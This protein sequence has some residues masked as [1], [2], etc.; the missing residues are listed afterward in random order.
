MQGLNELGET[1]L[2]LKDY[3]RA[4]DCQTKA[5]DI[6]VFLQ[7]RSEQWRYEAAAGKAYEAKGDKTKAIELL[8]AAAGTLRGVRSRIASEG[9]VQRFSEQEEPSGVYKLLIDLLMKSGRAEEARAYVD[10]S[11]SKLVKDAFGGVKPTV[12]D[13]ALKETLAGVDTSE[14]KKEAIEQEIRAERQKPEE[15][16]D[17][18]KLE[19]LTK[20]LAATEGEFNQW[21]MKLKFQ[22]RRMYDALSIKPATLGDV[23]RQV[24]AGAVFLEYFISPE[25]LYVFCIGREYF[26]ARSTAIAE[27]ELNTLVSRFVRACQ[28][29]PSGGPD[30]RLLDQ[31][32]RLYEVLIAPVKDVVAKYE[33]VVIVPFGPLYYLPFHALVTDESGKPEYLIERKRISYTTSATFADILKDQVRGHKSFMGFGNPDGSLPAASAELQG[34]QDK[35]FKSGAKVFTS[36]KATK[37]A[38]F[39]QAKNADILHLA[40]HGVIETNPL[41]S[42][43]LFAGATKEAQELTLLEVAGYTALRER[44][45]LVFLSACQTAKEA[46]KS[47]SGSELITLAEAFAMAGAPTLIATLWEV[48]D[49]ATRLFSETFYDQLANKN[50]DKLDAM[51]AGQI[52][53]IRSAEYTHPFYWA[54]FLMI[55]SWR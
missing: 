13:A 44:N 27:T 3:D 16:R 45:S 46:T 41:E 43:L 4:I 24:P 51:R 33:T 22:N 15:A 39:A 14:N 53:L 55:G 5:R 11:K 28:E 7:A 29:P 17:P 37:E 30:E 19:T 8:Q 42:Y 35:I 48:E 25:E 34:L 20:T 54:S 18:L 1:Y 10:E 6:A 9:L 36:G 52:A 38:F 40:T 26:L 23:Q 49:N 32:R 31:A 47:G 50:K 12:E 2:G 21:M